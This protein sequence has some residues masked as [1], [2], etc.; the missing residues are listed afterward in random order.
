MNIRFFY[1][2][3]LLSGLLLTTFS[4]TAQIGKEDSLL[5]AL[6]TAD[7]TQRVGLLNDL[8][9][10]Y[11]VKSPQKSLTYAR[12]ALAQVNSI[13]YPAQQARSLRT[14]GAAY[15][16]LSNYEKALQFFQHA[17]IV[18]E[19]IGDKQGLADT[20]NNIAIIYSEVLGQ[21]DEAMNYYRRALALAEKTGYKSRVAAILS[22]MANISAYKRDFKTA[23]DQYE[24]ALKLYE[25]LGNVSGQSAIYI[26]LG[27]AYYE[28]G[29]LTGA[30]SYWREALILA[31]QLGDTF[32]EA[33]IFHNLSRIATEQGRYDKSL[34]FN[35]QSLALSKEFP[36]VRRDNYEQIA[37][38]F[39]KQNNFRAAYDYKSRYLAVKDSLLEAE[40]SKTLTQLQSQYESERKERELEL[41][42]KDNNIKDLQV[43]QNR[44]TAIAS[45]TGALLLMVMVAVLLRQFLSKRRDNKELE[46]ANAQIRQT[47]EELETAN[48]QIRNSMAEKETLI[49]EAHHRVKNNLQL[50]SSLLNWQAEGIEDEEVLKLI[51]EGRSR[52]RSMALM[53]EYLYKSANL[54]NVDMNSYLGD[55]ID[56]L[57]RS[58]RPHSGIGV[59]KHIANVFFDADTVVPLG[60]IANELISNAFKYAFPNRTTG[61]VTVKLYCL[62]DDH[63][64]FSIEDDGIGLPPDFDVLHHESLGLQLVAT[65]V[66]QIKGTLKAWTDGGAHF[67]VEFKRR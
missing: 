38:N 37:I 62:A 7:P 60:L 23:T 54:M 26:N 16:G 21:R 20:Y 31:E 51:D 3:L 63:Y 52:I 25:E 8:A 13:Q 14:I 9:D 12:Q 47:V 32:Y 41:L 1:S 48:A 53:H 18:Y 28:Q 42:T 56:S 36:N 24:R 58:Y 33:T 55:L 40:K 19:R 67:T 44:L 27:D 10:F 15:Y 65:L 64:L 35:R 5:Q 49:K 46:A 45:L 4:A 57:A 30:E 34:D 11:V 22:N 43:K 61:L 6:S 59:R 50:V 66:Q 17:Q 29:D 39:E 2:F